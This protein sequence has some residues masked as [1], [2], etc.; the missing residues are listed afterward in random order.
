MLEAALAAARFHRPSL[1]ARRAAR[2][3]DREH[4]RDPRAKAGRISASPGI[5]TWCPPGDGWS[6]DP[7]EAR[8]RGR[9]AHRPRR[10]RHEERHRRFRRGRRRASSSG[11]G[12]ISL[13]IT[14]DEEG[15]ATYGT[16]RIIDW[17]KERDDPPG[18][19]PDRR[20]DL[21]RAARRHGE[22][23]P[24]RIGQH[25]DR[26]AGHAG[27]RRLPAP[28]RQS[29]P[30]AGAGCSRRSTP[31]ISTTAPTPSRRRT[32]NSPRSARRPRRATSSRRRRPRSS[33]SASTICSAAP[34]SSGWSRRSPSARRPA[35]PSARAFP[36]R[37]S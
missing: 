5:S 35:R 21:G 26:R 2:R 17:L 13:L 33:T 20:A 12:T 31:S 10:G 14:G 6:S 7:F 15:Y 24:A 27:P 32:W 28:R 11:S 16:P 8:H 29:D 30:E 23:R 37:R 3:P 34:T 19:D 4:G 36:A 25:V 9:H 18:H 1:R 22:D